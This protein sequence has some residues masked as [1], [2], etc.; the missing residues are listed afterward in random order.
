MYKVPVTFEVFLTEKQL[1]VLDAEVKKSFEMLIEADGLEPVLDLATV[2]EPIELS[3]KEDEEF[4]QAAVDAYR[5]QLMAIA[6]GL[7]HD[8]DVTAEE[9]QTILRRIF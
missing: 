2:G 9:A 5:T 8:P 7:T 3:S 4:V 1:P 6:D